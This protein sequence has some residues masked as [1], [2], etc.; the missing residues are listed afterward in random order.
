[1]QTTTVL[2]PAAGAIEVAGGV[3][4]LY[5]GTGMG[6]AALVLLTGLRPRLRRTS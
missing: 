6:I 5:I 1:M 3:F 4:F 2:R